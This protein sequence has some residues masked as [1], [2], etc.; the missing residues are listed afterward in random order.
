MGHSPSRRRGGGGGVELGGG[1]RLG[2]RAHDH[3]GYSQNHQF[4]LILKNWP[5]A[6]ANI[7]KGTD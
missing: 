4:E 7:V 3:E 1:V 6:M 2:S 5:K